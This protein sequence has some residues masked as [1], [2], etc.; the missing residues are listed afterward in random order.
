MK[1]IQLGTKSMQ[2]QSVPDID[3]MKGAR[4]G[5]GFPVISEQLMRNSHRSTGITGHQAQ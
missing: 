5:T 2:G 4:R 3:G 1:T